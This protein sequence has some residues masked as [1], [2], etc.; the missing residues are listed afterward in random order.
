[1]LFLFNFNTTA[2]R[3]PRGGAGGAR[4]GGAGGCSALVEIVSVAVA[5]CAVVGALL[6]VVSATWMSAFDLPGSHTP[7]PWKMDL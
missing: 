4:P 5:A 6:F 7:L 3:A 1:M 2:A